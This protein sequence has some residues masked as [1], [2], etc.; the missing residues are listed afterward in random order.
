MSNL[1]HERPLFKVLDAGGGERVRTIDEE[2]HGAG[3]HGPTGVQRRPSA[4]RCELCGSSRVSSR[5]L[6]CERCVAET[7]TVREARKQAPAV[8]TRAE[9]E[10]PAVRLRPGFCPRYFTQ[11]PVTGECGFCA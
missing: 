7:Q 1:N 10:R 11:L 9:A 3:V 2:L 8:T 6:R 5:R 4:P